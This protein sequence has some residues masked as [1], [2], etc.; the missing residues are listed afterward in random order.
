MTWSCFFT[1]RHIINYKQ[2]NLKYF[3]PV[4]STENP[5][6]G[7][8]ETLTV[9]LR[10]YRQIIRDRN[11]SIRVWI[12]PGSCSGFQRTVLEKAKTLGSDPSRIVPQPLSGISNEANVALIPVALQLMSLRCISLAT[13]VGFWKRSTSTCMCSEK[14][15]ENV[16]KS[17]EK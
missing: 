16:P 1:A 6:T 7:S 15:E 8:I 3:V 17:G 4:C 11:P 10:A 13:R 12:W 14:H 5:W 2:K 9:P